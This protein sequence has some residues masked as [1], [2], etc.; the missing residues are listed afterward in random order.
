ML[1]ERY[2]V[3]KRILFFGLGRICEISLFFGLE[4]GPGLEL[5][6]GPAFEPELFLLKLKSFVFIF[7]STVTV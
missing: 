5:G 4:F 6:P 7:V 1:P 3:M 2:S